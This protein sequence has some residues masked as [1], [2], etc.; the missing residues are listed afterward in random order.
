MK[1]VIAII[2]PT[3]L[4]AVH[5]ALENV[6]VHRL[7]VCDGQGYGQQRG[8]TEAQPGPDYETTLHRKIALEIVVNEDFLARTLDAISQVARTGPEGAIGDGKILVV[9]VE[10]TI[11]LSDRSE[12]PGAV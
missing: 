7:T 2:Q 10:R 11:R 8:W 12:G 4:T 1:M 5:E 9:P 3:K 6:D